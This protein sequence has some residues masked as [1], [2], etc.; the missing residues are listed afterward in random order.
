MNKS[1]IG[2]AAAL[3]TA[4]LLLYLFDTSR[5]AASVC[6]RQP[7]AAD[8]GPDLKRGIELYQKG[9]FN[10]ALEALREATRKHKNDAE[11][12]HFLGLTLF[13]TN[14]LKG[15]RKA[16]ETSSQ[17][18]PGFAPTHYNLAY[19]LLLTNKTS[20]AAREARRA[21]ELDANVAEAHYILGM[22]YLREGS[23]S[24]ALEE[25]E[26]ALKLQSAL[27]LA[28]LLKSQALTYLYAEQPGKLTKEIS[29]R[30]L[31]EATRATLMEEAKKRAALLKGAA[32]SLEQYLKL[33]PEDPASASWRAQMET[34]R[35]YT[36]PAGKDQS[37]TARA[38]F[39]P[40]EVDVKARILSRPNPSYTE[41]A[42][43]AQISG[44]VVVRAILAAD[45][46]VKHVLVIRALPFG[47]TEEAV[48]AAREIKFEPAM[49][50][51]QPVSQ[52]VQI[53][54]EFSVY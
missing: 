21:L 5:L 45:R 3:A 16:F 30:P 53:E 13:K 48:R 22:A 15:A 36:Q 17:L 47:L 28:F 2:S 46:T 49:K 18:R 54:Y 24:M 40:G 23:A 7:Q 10:E 34:L 41:Q 37:D 31:D 25:A 8:A 42:R 20:E 32:D 1:R 11:A 12:W 43:K 39:A 29:L 35:T 38:F 6:A 27:P 4:A 52:I 50:D 9:A 19:V 26:A 33:A 51:G 14:D 44:M